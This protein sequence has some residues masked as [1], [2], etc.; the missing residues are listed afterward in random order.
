VT[1]DEIDAAQRR[2]DREMQLVGWCRGFPAP[3][4]IRLLAAKGIHLEPVDAL[5][6]CLR[7]VHQSPDFQF[8]KEAVKR[9]QRIAGLARDLANL[10][11]ETPGDG[12]WRV[13]HDLDEPTGVSGAVDVTEFVETLATLEAT[14]RQRVEQFGYAVE[15][16]VRPGSGRA[17]TSRYFYWLALLAFWRHGMGR[18]IATSTDALGKAT[19]PLVAYMEIMSAGMEDRASTGAMQKFVQRHKRDVARFARKFMPSGVMRMRRFADIVGHGR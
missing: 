15:A 18:E 16:G 10:L 3:N 5:F 2:F 12:D 9:E 17:P 11:S 4:A 1:D 19:G 7:N 14:A 13:V 6:E 8:S